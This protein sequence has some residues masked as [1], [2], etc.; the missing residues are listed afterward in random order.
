MSVAD[1]LNRMVYQ[2]DG[3]IDRL[4]A[5]DSVGECEDEDDVFS[6]SEDSSDSEEGSALGA[7]PK[8]RCAICAG[9]NP[10]ETVLIPCGHLS[11]EDCWER[12]TKRHVEF[13]DEKYDNLR[14]RRAQKKKVPCFSCRTVAVS[15]NKIF[16]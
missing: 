2:D 6:D 4:N 15:A 3:F 14:I 10:L 16:L 1:F 9:I 8:G 7:I 12:W 5:F 13:C 11:C